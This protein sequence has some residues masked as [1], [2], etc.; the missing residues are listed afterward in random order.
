MLGMYRV[1]D[2]T[3]ERGNLAAF[4]LAGLGADVV[5]IEHPVHP[6]HRRLLRC[7]PPRHPAVAPPAER[8]VSTGRRAVRGQGPSVEPGTKGPPR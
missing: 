4:I 3:D 7:Q 5:L 8:S 6:E 2:L 1:L